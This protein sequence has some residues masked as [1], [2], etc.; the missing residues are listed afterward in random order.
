MLSPES[1]AMP[2]EHPQFDDLIRALFV[3][4]CKR[5]R[6]SV[7]NKTHYDEMIA[8]LK[9]E[10]KDKVLARKHR[11]ALRRYA[12]IEE[13]GEFSIVRKSQ[14]FNEEIRRL[15]HSMELYDIISGAH[16]A[17][18]YSTLKLF[19][20]LS[21]RYSNISFPMCDAYMQCYRDVNP[22]VKI[23]EGYFSFIDM[24]PLVGSGDR[25]KWTLLYQDFPTQRIYA[26]E[27]RNN[28]V[29]STAKELLKIFILDGPPER[30][31]SNSRRKFTRK[32]LS[33]IKFIQPQF[34]ILMMKGTFH[35]QQVYNEVDFMNKL[36]IW[37]NTNITIHWTYGIYYCAS[38]LNKSPLDLTKK[39]NCF[40]DAP[41]LAQ[42]IIEEAARSREVTP[43]TTPL[44]QVGESGTVDRDSCTAQTTAEESAKSLEF[45]PLS[46]V[47]RSDVSNSLLTSFDAGSQDEEEEGIPLFSFLIN[48][49]KDLV[50]QT[51]AVDSSCT[52]QTTAE[53]SANRLEL[54]P[55]S[56]VDRR[57]VSNSLLTSGNSSSMAQTIID[58]AGRS[59]E[60]TPLSPVDLRDVSNSLLT[61]VDAESQDDEDGDEMDEDAESQDDEDGN[62]M[63]EEGIIF[64]LF[65]TFKK[66]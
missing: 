25:I 26:R 62:E 4:E 16:K 20:Y 64:Y 53:G 24:T 57:D 60:V 32:V 37:L 59:R 8:V 17:T 14:A 3:E 28:S 40:R 51:G 49:S 61:S 1:K 38:D 52:A 41:I 55:L 46:T 7:I 2:N 5:R 54:T 50:A 63:D 30:L 35:T 10:M 42:A 34:N 65:L 48:I 31:Y 15:V 22:S 21:K 43:H 29:K 58:E 19:E 12:L 18:Q 66:S 44:H 23:R 13:E 11:N 27:M 36:I 6:C 47:D 56:T 9:G 39:G 45:T 33:R